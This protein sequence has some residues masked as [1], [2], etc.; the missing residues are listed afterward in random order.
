MTNFSMDSTLTV[1]DD[2]RQISDY[3]MNF[4]QLVDFGSDFEQKLSFCVDARAAFPNLEVVYASLVHVVN[5]LAVDTWKVMDGRHTRKTAAFVKSCVAYNFVT[6][7]SIIHI[8][9][10]LDLYLLTGKV[11]L[12]NACLGQADA[13]FEGALHLILEMPKQFEY[14]GKLRGSDAYLLCYVKNFL[15]TLIIVPDSPD[16]GVLY[17]VRTLIDVVK[18]YGFETTHLIT[19]YF[20]ILDTLCVMSQ[21]VY[22]YHVTDGKVMCED[23]TCAN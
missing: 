20:D 1:D 6:I 9:T 15:A 22:P 7:P 8:A 10:R 18:K 11:A 17:L 3:V 16:Q 21:E 5:K 14:D 23:F 4:I 13:C 19:I 2:R 12:L